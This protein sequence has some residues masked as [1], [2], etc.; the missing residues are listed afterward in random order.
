[1]SSG[2]PQYEWSAFPSPTSKGFIYYFAGLF[3]IYITFKNNTKTL[4]KDYLSI[5][6][7]GR[8][9]AFYEVISSPF[10]SIQEVTCLTRIS[11]AF[12]VS[13]T[14]PCKNSNC[15]S[16]WK[17]EFDVISSCNKNV[18]NSLPLKGKGQE[19]QYFFAFK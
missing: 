11:V 2:R 6:H 14:S 13:N 4:L 8:N 3:E 10:D 17:S 18:M 12:R 16:H 5:K 9:M 15:I 1:M 7:V 19:S